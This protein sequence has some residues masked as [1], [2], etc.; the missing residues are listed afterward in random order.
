MIPAVVKPMYN[1]HYILFFRKRGLTTNE[2][3]SW[4][5]DEPPNTAC[6]IILMPSEDA[7]Q[8]DEDSEDDDTTDP[9]DINHLGKGTLIQE[10][11]MDI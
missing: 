1:V 8:S 4:F 6:D 10:A 3:A 9:K 2:I 11:E 5:E 7:E